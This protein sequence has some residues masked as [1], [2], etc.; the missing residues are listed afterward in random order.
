MLFSQLLFEYY[1]VIME[2]LQTSFVATRSNS[3]NYG[4]SPAHTML[5]I[6][7]Y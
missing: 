6:V 1:T 7:L 4:Q 3:I 2:K 5:T